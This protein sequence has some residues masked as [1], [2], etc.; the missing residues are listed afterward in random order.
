MWF[1]QQCCLLEC[2]YMSTG[3]QLMTFGS[4]FLFRAKQSKQNDYA[5]RYELLFLQCL[6][7]K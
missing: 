3:K 2:S 1:S 7:V 6:T 5:G 4:A